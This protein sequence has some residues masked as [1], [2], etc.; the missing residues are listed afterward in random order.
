MVIGMLFVHPAM[1]YSDMNHLPGILAFIV[2]IP[3]AP[4]FL[5]ALGYAMGMK[6]REPARVL[7]RAG[8]ILVAALAFGLMIRLLT[9][10]FVFSVLFTA[11]IGVLLV[12][13]S[14]TSKRPVTVMSFL[15]LFIAMLA[16]FLNRTHMF[17][18]LEN[19]VCLGTQNSFWKWN[20]PLAPYVL[21]AL[22]GG[23]HAAAPNQRRESLMAV[24]SAL[25]FSL[26]GPFLS[27]PTSL[28]ALYIMLIIA[29]AIALPN[30]KSLLSAT[31]SPLWLRDLGMHALPIYFIHHI[32]L[33]LLG[34]IFV[35]E[36]F[37]YTHMLSFPN[38]AGNGEIMLFT[39]IVMVVI[40]HFSKPHKVS[41][42]T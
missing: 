11:A 25:L 36:S 38:P 24:L 1:M 23:M 41:V 39:V 2:T 37:T 17:P 12:G 18:F 4:G 13:F 14:M 34:I 21:F 7:R 31:D 16:L 5:Y 19:I 29:T 22:L 6:K 30:L 9:G 3:I 42:T 10:E 27:H 28:G 8:I 26:A 32:V 15:A 33:W 40:I 20:T 35:G